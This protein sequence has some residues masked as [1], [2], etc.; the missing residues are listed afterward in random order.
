MN[1]FEA[2]DRLGLVVF[3]TLFVL[4]RNLNRRPDVAFVSLERWPLERD[5]PT[6]NAWEVV[7]DLAIEVVS[8]TNRT[9]DDMEKIEEYF[10]AV[11]DGSGSSIRDS[12]RCMTTARRRAST[13]S[14][15]A[16]NSTEVRCCRDSGSLSPC[17][18]KANPPKRDPGST[19]G[20]KTLPRAPDGGG[21][22]ARI[23]G[24]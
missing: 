21:G 2:M 23:G 12:A 10:R 3:E 5:V 4:D 13:F 15:S 22:G 11:H 14:K 17:F 8:P 9:D 6:S 18:S 1:R 24:E 19:E 20:T 16:T 7:P